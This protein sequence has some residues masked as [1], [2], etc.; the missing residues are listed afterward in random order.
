MGERHWEYSMNT[1]KN[2]FGQSCQ[3]CFSLLSKI[4]WK[5]S[6]NLC[7]V[8]IAYEIFSRFPFSLIY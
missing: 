8:S 2:F 4:R 7:K 6:K 3:E 1:Q 5:S